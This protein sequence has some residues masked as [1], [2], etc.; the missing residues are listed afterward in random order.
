MEIEEIKDR[1]KEVLIL[2]I[3]LVYLLI[4]FIE[5]RILK[6]NYYECPFCEHVTVGYKITKCKK[7]GI[8]IEEMKKILNKRYA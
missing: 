1:M 4:L 8:T 6:K 7:C 5:L 2:P 3:F